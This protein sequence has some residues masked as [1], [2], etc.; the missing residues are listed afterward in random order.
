[1]SKTDTQRVDSIVSQSLRIDESEFDDDTEFGPEGLDADSIE[2]IEM[3][4]TLDVQMDVYIPDEQIDDLETI[5]DVKE[6]V[7][8]HKSS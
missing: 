7:A 3:V 2:L 1:M 5:G 8:S 4:E 6:Y